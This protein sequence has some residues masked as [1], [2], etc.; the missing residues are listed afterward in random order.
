MGAKS[1]YNQPKK[2][3]ALSPAKKAKVKSEI[4]G[5]KA[6]AKRELVPKGVKKAKF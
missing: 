3:P 2:A 4:R 6:K 1:G 5:H